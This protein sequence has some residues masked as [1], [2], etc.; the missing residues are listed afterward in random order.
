M[1]K[2]KK[3]LSVLMLVVSPF[4]LMQQSFAQDDSSG[5]YKTAGDFQQRVLSYAINCKTEKHKIKLNDFFNKPYLFVVHNDST[6]KLYKKDIFGYRF[7]S[8][9]VYRT[10]G[11]NE[12]QV[13]NYEEPVIIIYRINISKPPT[14][15]TNVTNYYFSKDAF[16]PVLKLTKKNL[17]EAFPGNQRFHEQ[18]DTRFKYN[19][20]LASFDKV[21]SMYSINW[22]YQNTTKD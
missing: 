5:I 4:I 8:G 12:Y 14:G 18:L 7:C 13:L 9:E 3:M 2:M 1:K 11:K 20:E 21:H 10:K 6:I 16:S 15:K 19:T 17:K 22:I